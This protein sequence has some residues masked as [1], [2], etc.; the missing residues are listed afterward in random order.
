MQKLK[1]SLIKIDLSKPEGGRNKAILETMYSCGL[2]VSEVL[3]LKLS[4]LHLD[5]GFIR[6]IGKGDKERLVP[7]GSSAIKYIGI[8]TKNIRVHVQPKKGKEDF[9]FL[10]KYGNELSRVMIFLI[11]KQLA[12]MAGIKK[13]Y[14]HIPSVIRL[15]HIW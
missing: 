15:Q 12:G 8:Y 10:N 13:T 11:I 7:I 4:N 1:V 2:R 9:L 5:V 3:N 6:V 14:R